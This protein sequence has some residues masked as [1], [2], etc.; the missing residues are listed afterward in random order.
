MTKLTITT[1]QQQQQQQFIVS[2]M[3]TTVG[4]GISMNGQLVNNLRFTENDLQ[5]LQDIPHRGLPR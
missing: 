1:K 5:Q 2:Y 4:R 3:W